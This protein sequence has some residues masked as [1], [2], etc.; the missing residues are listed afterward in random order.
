MDNNDHFKTGY[1]ALVGKPNV[2][3]S[4]ILNGLL[5]FKLSIVTPKPQTTRRKILGILNGDNYQVVFTDTPGIISPAYDLQKI[6][7]QYVDKAMGDA[8]IICLLVEPN[9]KNPELP[10]VFHSGKLTGKPVILVINKMDLVEKAELL[11]LMDLYKKCFSFAAII[12]VSA[13]HNEG[14]DRLLKEIIQHLPAH[15]PYYPLDF[16]S[17]QN[18]RFFV[19]EI[20]REKIFQLYSKEIPY[21][22]HVEIEEFSENPGRKDLIRAVIY[23]DHNSQKGILIGKGGRAL[24]QVGQHAREDIETFLER[25]VYLELY[26]KVL[27]NWRKKLSTLKN[28]GF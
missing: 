21:A 14:L 26:V 12:P 9:D 10:E 27:Q 22:C 4:T 11:P 17:D 24:K 13:L 6:L 15:P 1:V 8:D 20:I 3:K 28:L 16:V 25:P 5:D 18:E 2:G 7:M 19:A 23:V